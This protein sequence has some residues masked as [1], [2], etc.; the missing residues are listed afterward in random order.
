MRLASLVAELKIMKK[1]EDGFIEKP[2]EGIEEEKARW[3]DMKEL[4]EEALFTVRQLRLLFDK[5]KLLEY[6]ARI[7]LTYR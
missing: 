3:W 7:E 2:D 1:S 4:K 5:R 6:A